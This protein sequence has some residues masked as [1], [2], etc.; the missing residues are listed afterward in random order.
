MP[1]SKLASVSKKFATQLTK[2]KADGV[3]QSNES[4]NLRRTAYAAVRAPGFKAKDAATF[5]KEFAKLSKGA[6]DKAST[7]GYLKNAADEFNHHELVSQAPAMV[8][9]ALKDLV[10]TEEW[11][12]I[13]APGQ[14]LQSGSIFG[15]PNA[16]VQHYLWLDPARYTAGPEY[17]AEKIARLVQTSPAL[18]KLKPVITTIAMQGYGGYSV[19]DLLKKKGDLEVPALTAAATKVPQHSIAV[20]RAALEKLES[21]GRV[22]LPDAEKLLDAVSYDV[23]ENLT[24]LDK[25]K[26]YQAGLKQLLPYADHRVTKDVLLRAQAETEIAVKLL[27]ALPGVRAAVAGLTGPAAAN[28]DAKKPEIVG[29]RV[30]VYLKRSAPETSTLE[31]QLRA[32]FPELGTSLAVSRNYDN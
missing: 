24:T 19:A 9:A 11:A 7:A 2:Y 6:T 31:Q 28:L 3:I 10:Q 1:S 20:L 18:A 23:A 21:R 22:I 8:R 29:A 14:A 27:T 25:A 32:Q 15:S 30:V 5:G 16:K 26:A 4:K 13:L 17:Y 12:G